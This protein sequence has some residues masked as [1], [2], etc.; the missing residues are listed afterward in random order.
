LPV[1][2]LNYRGGYMYDF[3]EQTISTTNAPVMTNESERSLD[4]KGQMDE[5]GVM[6]NKKDATK[7]GD[8]EKVAEEKIVSKTETGKDIGD[9]RQ[10][11]EITGVTA[12]KNFNETAFFYPELRTDENGEILIK[13]QVPE[14]LTKCI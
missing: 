4:G 3:M 11:G 9:N 2:S 5:G 12:R 1:Y 8:K 7:N 14:A 13:F 10:P 6:L